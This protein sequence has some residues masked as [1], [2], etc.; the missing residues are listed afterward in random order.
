LLCKARQAKQ[1]REAKQS[2]ARE[3]AFYRVLIKR[4]PFFIKDKTITM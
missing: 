3:E 2:K 4:F 1:A